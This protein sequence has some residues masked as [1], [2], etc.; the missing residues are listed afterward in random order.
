MRRQKWMLA[1]V[2]LGLGGC[3]GDDGARLEPVFV[4]DDDAS[5]DLYVTDAPVDDAFRVVLNFT[6][7]QFLRASA[8]P[9]TFLF[10][11]PRAIDVLAL[12]GGGLEQL[13]N[14]A[15]LPAQSYSGIRLLVDSELETPASFVELN[16]GRQFPVTTLGDA[17]LIDAPFELEGDASADLVVDID[18]RRS[19]LFRE[20]TLEFTLLDAARLIDA[21][22]AGGIA[23][24]VPQGLVFDAA[25]DNGFNNDVGNLVMAF[26]G[27]DVPIDDMDGAGDAVT[28]APVVLDPAT[29]DYRF[30]LP[31]LSAGHYTL[32]FTCQGLN[33]EPLSDDPLEFFDPGTGAEVVAGETTAF[34]FPDPAFG[35]VSVTSEDTVETVLVAGQN[36]NLSDGALLLPQQDTAFPDGDLA[37]PEPT[38]SFPEPTFSIPE[39][40]SSFPEQEPVF[41]STEPVSD[42]TEG[43]SVFVFSGGTQ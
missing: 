21:A 24:T 16:D 6:G 14:D 2:L 5:V 12:A 9:V 3:G 23:G 27:A 4:A 40:E 30:E 22:E 8:P 34:D 37:F 25:C 42:F 19:L 7:V 20:S 43:D 28:S 10:D 15:S 18:L 13:L 36:G 31:L 29:G 33:D 11:S 26:A 32:A 35:G 39:Q 17:V 38:S 41:G 1:L